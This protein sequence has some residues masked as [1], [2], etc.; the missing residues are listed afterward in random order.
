MIVCTVT[1][2][3]AHQMLWDISGLFLIEAIIKKKKEF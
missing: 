2:K 1:I 3:N